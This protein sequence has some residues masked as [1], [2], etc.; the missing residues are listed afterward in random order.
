MDDG[1][2]SAEYS[3]LK[4]KSILNN[5]VE[6]NTRLSS[7]SD[8]VQKCT[9]IE[10]MM[11]LAQNYN[12]LHSYVNKVT[13]I[14]LEFSYFSIQYSFIHLLPLVPPTGSQGGWTLSQ[15]PVGE[16]RVQ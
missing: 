7:S 13:F 14:S 11:M 16:G 9:S 12:D 15:L 3:F 2:S 10:D 1:S 4:G 8:F 6:T 5:R